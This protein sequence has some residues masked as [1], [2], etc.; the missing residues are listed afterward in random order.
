[1]STYTNIEEIEYQI[2]NL[3]MRGISCGNK[4]DNIVLCLHGWLDNAASF[5]P[6]MSYFEDELINKRVIAIDWPGH[7]NSSRNGN[8]DPGLTTRP[9][10]SPHCPWVP[11]A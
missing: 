7:G 3:T 1:M 2:G 8:S 5:L 11:H 10:W 9:H 4:H 6:L